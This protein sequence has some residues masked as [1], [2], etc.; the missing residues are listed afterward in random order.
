MNTLLVREIR[1]K[2]IL[3]KFKIHDYVINPYVGCQHG[4]S[5]CYARFMK[6]FSN[7]LEPWGKFVDVKINAAEL[8]ASEIE[9]KK[10]GTVWVSGVCDP[11]QPLERRYC[12]TRKCLDILADHGWPVVIQTR[13]P[14]ILRDLDIIGGSV[15]MRAGLSITTGNDEV[16][17][18]F[19]PHATSISDRVKTLERLHEEGIVTYAMI[20]PILPGAEKLGKL[21]AGKV[22][23]IIV[24][25]MNYHYADHIYRKYGIEKALSQRYFSEVASSLVSFC[26][27]NGIECRVEF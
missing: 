22:D 15:A 5:Y 7:H 27:I 4:C 6:K 12:L 23:Y 14:L 25:R 26:R 13:S 8:L 2:T 21:L 20:A 18:I 24:D 3:T 1:S 9:R 17:K 10:T 16:R 19:E 11:Y